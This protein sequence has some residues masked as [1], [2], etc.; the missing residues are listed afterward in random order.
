MLITLRS[1]VLKK[2][3]KINDIE[4]FSGQLVGIFGPVDS[5]K[6]SILVA[7]LGLSILDTKFDY[8][9]KIDGKDIG[10]IPTIPSQLFTGMKKSLRGE[11]ELSAQFIGKIPTN[12][13][14]ISKK[15]KIYDFLNRDPFTLSGGEMVRAAIAINAVREPKI[16]ILDQIYDWLND[17][18]KDYVRSFFESER[19]EGKA[20]VESHSIKPK[21]YN[22]FD[23]KLYLENFHCDKKFDEENYKY[24]SNTLTR[25][26]K[27]KRILK[28]ENLFYQYPKNGFKLGPIGI[29]CYEGDII[30]IIGENG[31]GKTTLLQCIANLQDNIVGNIDINGKI[32]TKK[33]WEWAKNAIYC[34][35]NPDDQLYSPTV[36]DEVLTTLKA[37]GV[38]VKYGKDERIEEFGLLGKI[39]DEPYHLPRPLRRMVSFAACIISQTPVVLLD[40]PTANLDE[41]LKK[42]IY[43]EIC[44]YNLKGWVIIMISHDIEFVKKIANRII[45][46]EEGRIKEDRKNI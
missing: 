26:K 6:S 30:A 41:N 14:E 10:Y 35:Q 8:Y 43:K 5:G 42:I 19:Y 15:L 28:I 20:I 46:L 17:V 16:W 18:S 24:Q 4:I 25:V 11:L 38:D 40:E 34:F 1:A 33:K 36:K 22:E 45:L 32:P 9:S 21:W 13:D 3:K 31:S 29:D 37:L 44:E 23:K 12:I 27:A 2:T 7:M 39:N